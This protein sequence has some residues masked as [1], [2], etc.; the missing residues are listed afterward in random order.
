MVERDHLHCI[1]NFNCVAKI[2]S[3]ICNIVVIA[4]LKTIYVYPLN[5]FLECILCHFY[6]FIIV[7]GI[8]F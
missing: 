1:F 3:C 7:L 6:A 5:D 2:K 4:N 8:L